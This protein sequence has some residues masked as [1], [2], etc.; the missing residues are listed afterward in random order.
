MLNIYTQKNNNNIGAEVE[1]GARANEAKVDLSKYED[2]T[3]EFTSSQF[4]KSVWYAEHRVLLYKI[5][6][7]LLIVVASAT[8]LYSLFAWG[9]Y[10]FV[11]M[12]ED[13]KI[14]KKL[15]GS[16][17]Y[18]V[19]H[20]ATDPQPIQMAQ[21]MVL[22]GGVEKF[23]F[24]AE[25]ANPNERH[26]VFFDYYFEVDGTKTETKKS[27]LLA[28]ENRPLAFFGYK[29]YPSSV[30][31]NLENISWSFVSAHEIADASA[32]QNE[33]LKFEIKNFVFSDR[34]S[35]D[36][37][38]AHAVRFSLDNNT[39]FSY[40]DPEF[41]VGL[42]SNDALVGVMPLKLKNFKSL[43]TRDVD[44]RSYVDGI[45]ITDVRVFPLIDIYDRAV[46]LAP[47]G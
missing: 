30:V 37:I 13:A 40:V 17:D 38:G 23:D 8:V 36:E 35:S 45:S 27:F 26:I 1:N 29:G 33:R 9:H 6:V 46:Y 18:S 12:S 43:E 20:Q 25:V 32:W 5:F 41:V 14:S 10:I 4:K 2:P 19:L 34:F 11:G 3:G 24:V 28:G 44:L 21:A 7:W 16:F 39:A 47:E 42:Y 22:P 31:L 15:S